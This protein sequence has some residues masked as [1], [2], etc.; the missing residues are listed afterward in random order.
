MTARPDHRHHTIS[1]IVSAVYCEQK[2]IFD[3]TYG[4]RENDDVRA[5][6]EDGITQHK[7]FERAARRGQ[8]RRC[9]IA[10]A[11][12]GPEAPETRFLRAWRDRKLMPTRPGRALVRTYYLVSPLLLPLLSRHARLARL[13]RGALD[14]LVRF[15]EDK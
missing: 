6:R 8:D 4:I 11:V 1:D 3:R 12:Y 5:W 10:T 2:M 7:H 9:F 14:R 15:L 13:V